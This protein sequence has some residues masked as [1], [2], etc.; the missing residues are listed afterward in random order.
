[1]YCDVPLIT[2]ESVIKL[3]EEILKKNCDVVG[4][5]FEYS[6]NKP[7]GRFELNENGQ[8]KRVV[9]ASD[10]D[11]GFVSN[12]CN[13]GMELSDWLSKPFLSIRMLQNERS[14]NFG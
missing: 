8:V 11:N 14:K 7:Y 2:I 4:T 5:A 9:E 13:A 3:I 12:L 6:G 10:M 1:M